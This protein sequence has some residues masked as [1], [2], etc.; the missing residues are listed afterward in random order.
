MSRIDDK[1]DPGAGGERC[2]ESNPRCLKC[3][4]DAGVERT[5]QR[6][7][8]RIDEGEALCQCH[9]VFPA[10]PEAEQRCKKCAELIAASIR[11]CGFC[12]ASVTPVSAEAAARDDGSM[13]E[14]Q[15]KRAALIAESRSIDLETAQEL[16]YL[17]D[18]LS[19][20]ITSS[21]VEGF[22]DLLPL[23]AVRFAP[24]EYEVRA[25]D[26]RTLWRMEGAALADWVCASVNGYNA[27]L[28]SLKQKEE[29]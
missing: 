13:T 28:E 8:A 20:A 29:N 21:A 7:K 3:G 14:T 2:A 12:G 19:T 17:R 23:A 6:C 26:G 22:E 18:R 5:L 15:L 4:H 1:H 25:R 10:P 24:G 9:C 16:V 11:F 27:A